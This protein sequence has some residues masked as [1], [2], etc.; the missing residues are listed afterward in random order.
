M[1]VK[2][3]KQY[4]LTPVSIAVGKQMVSVSKDVEKKEHLN[5]ISSVTSSTLGNLIM[6]KYTYTQEYK[7]I[8][9]LWNNMETPQKS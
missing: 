7:L 8:E 2:I 3:P 5:T 6:Y 9:L 4:H 1:Q